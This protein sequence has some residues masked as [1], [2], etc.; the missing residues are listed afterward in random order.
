MRTSLLLA[1]PLGIAIF[2]WLMMSDPQS[3]PIR[4]GIIQFTNNNATTLAGFKQGLQDAGL[5]ENQEVIY[6]DDGPV[7]VRRQLAEAVRKLL[8][9]R[10]QL[11]FTSTTPAARTVKAITAAESPGLPVVFAPVN[12][13]LTAGLV[14]SMRQ[15]EA[16]LTGVRLAVSD[17]RRLQSLQE[18]FPAVKIVCVPFSPNDKAAEA[19]L[20]QL[21]TAAKKLAIDLRPVAFPQVF[22]KEQISSLIPPD[23]DA[24]LL[25][26]EGRIASRSKDFSE[27]AIERR[28]P[29]SVFRF[30]QIE[31]DG[32]L[33]YGFVGWQVGKQAARLAKQILQGT[34]VAHLPVETARDYLF[35]NLDSAARMQLEFPDAALRRA[36]FTVIDGRKVEHR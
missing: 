3:E 28:L 11:I 19:S 23:S 25:P 7:T 20:D 29:L 13:P 36:H 10:P 33:G 35:L 14:K 24:L 1:I 22:S 18:I 27:V 2:I 21:R 15:P 31:T 34:P 16:N 6:L 30:A 17:G 12:D 32:L 5:R 9:K 26:R 4:I 8:Q